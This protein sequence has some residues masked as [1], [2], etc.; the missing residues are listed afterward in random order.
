[1]PNTVHVVDVADGEFT[2]LFDVVAV[3]VFV[4]VVG[5]TNDISHV[6][7]DAGAGAAPA[8]EVIV[9]SRNGQTNNFF[10]SFC[11]FHFRVVFAGLIGDGPVM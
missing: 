8:T 7:V 9:S 5:V 3:V 6:N 11:V 2:L 4:A 10:F 1:M